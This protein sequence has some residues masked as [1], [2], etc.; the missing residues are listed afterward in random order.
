MVLRTLRAFAWMRWRVL[1]NSLERTGSRDRLERLS[2]AVEQI[3]PLI[4]IALVAPSAVGLA[5]LGGY[6]GYWLTADAPVMTFEALRIMLLAACG[7]AV[8]GPLLMP[9]MEPTALVRLLLLPIPRRT[10]YAAQTAGAL[11]EPWVIISVPVVLSIPVGLAFGGAWLAASVSLIAG[12]LLVLCLIGLSTLS[13][14]VLHLVVRDR[15]RGELLALLFIML[16]PAIVLL[17]GLL[18]QP[19]HRPEG[20][21]SPADSE[22][23]RRSP[24]PMPAWVARTADVAYAVVPSELFTRATRSSARHEPQGAAVPLFVLVTSGALL[25]TLGMLTFVRLLDSPSAGARRRP[26]SKAG[27]GRVWIPFLSRASAAVAQGQLR[28]AMRTPR[29]RSIL[30]TPFVLF[31]LF[32]IVIYRQGQMELGL[33]N[34]ANGLSLATFGGSVCLLAILPFAMNQFAIDR[35][36]LTMALLSPLATREL[37]TGKAV[38]N[39]LIAGGPALLCMLVAFVLFPSGTPALWLSLPPA[40]VAT[41]LLAAPGAAT[42]SALFPR[43]VDLNSIGRGSNAHGLANLLGLLVFVAAGLPSVLIILLTTRLVHVPALTPI[44]MLAWCGVA[45]ILSRLL[46]GGVAVLFD[47]RRENL[48]IVAS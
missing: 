42:L 28:L 18:T 30:L 2:L 21:A 39:G 17:P 11:S 35:S 38:G 34:L 1:L 29:G 33:I 14:L 6:A 3:G 44:V 36:G 9:S 10:L 47:K 45:L 4:A 15:R 22:H 26:T 41:Y 43:T 40:L 20:P 32:A 16:V 19:R 7:F 13:T 5:G 8:V 31:V 27:P 12:L 24:T 46:F 48:G 25:H 23:R 37:L